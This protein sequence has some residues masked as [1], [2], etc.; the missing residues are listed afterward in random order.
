MEWKYDD[1]IIMEKSDMYWDK[2]IVKFDKVK[3]VMVSDRNIDYQMFQFGE[4]DI[5]YVFV[6]L[7]DQLLDQDNVSIVD[8][9]GFYFY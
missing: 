3:W 8:Q 4:L 7:S 9:V 6:E 5:V 2:D 1:S